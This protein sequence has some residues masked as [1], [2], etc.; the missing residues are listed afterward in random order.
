MKLTAGGSVLVKLT[1]GA[2]AGPR[3]VMAIEYVRLLL[4]LTNTTSGVATTPN[5]RSAVVGLTVV[6]A[7]TTLFKKFGSPSRPSSELVLTAK[8]ATPGRPTMVPV[9]VASS[10]SVPIVQTSPPLSANAPWVALLDTS[11]APAGRVLVRMI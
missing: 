5:A 9:A 7:V 10:A 1:P 2:V 11:V 6:V 3:F 4:A 8:P